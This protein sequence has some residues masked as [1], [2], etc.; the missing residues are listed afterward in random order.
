MRSASRYLFVI[1]MCGSSF[2]K[3]EAQCPPRP[4]DGTVVQDA[5]SIISM[6]G[7]LNAELTMRHSVDTG[8]YNHYCMN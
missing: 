4:N 1:L 8:G 3:S 6:N 5:L 2:L 7:V